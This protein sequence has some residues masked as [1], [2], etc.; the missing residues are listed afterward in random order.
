MFFSLDLISVSKLVSFVTKHL[1]FPREHLA[2]NTARWHF[3]LTYVPVTTQKIT[4]P[5]P[6]GKQSQ[7]VTG[8]DH[9]WGAMRCQETSADK[10]AERRAKN[11]SWL[12]SRAVFPHGEELDRTVSWG[13]IPE[14]QS[15][16]KIKYRIT[17]G[18]ENDASAHAGTSLLHRRE[19]GCR[20]WASLWKMYF[21][22]FQ[23]Y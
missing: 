4:F 9:R 22:I 5:S 3:C 17:Q 2:K 20:W 21:L 18:S 7:G 14:S 10:S 15:S 19:S 16:V 13:N 6:S 12:P 11:W 1:T 23:L 8:R